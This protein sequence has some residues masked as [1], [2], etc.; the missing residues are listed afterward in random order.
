MAKP[1][2]A[3]EAAKK[4]AAA[5]KSPKPAATAKAAPKKPT[6]DF[7]AT[8]SSLVEMI[9]ADPSTNLVKFLNALVALLSGMPPDLAKEILKRIMSALQ[10][11]ANT[12]EAQ[13]ST[14]NPPRPGEAAPSGTSAGAPAPQAPQARPAMRPAA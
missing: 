4:E 9:S 13:P 6:G 3:R 5:A 11:G 14:P 8:W 7:E 10:G 2:Y 12:T 1:D